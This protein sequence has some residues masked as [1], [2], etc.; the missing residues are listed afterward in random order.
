MGAGMTGRD[1]LMSAHALRSLGRVIEAIG[2]PE[3]AGEL[4]GTLLSLA[5]FDNL[6]AVAFSPEGAPRPL[7]TFVRSSVA[8]ELYTRHY[9]SGAYRLDPYYLA[10][11]E[12][13]RGFYRL[14]DVVPDLFFQGEYFRGYYERTGLID[15]IGLVAPL[16]DRLWLHFSL[17]RG[18]RSR[19]FSRAEL[20][21]LLAMEPIV[22]SLVLRHWRDA[23]VVP[24][25]PELAEV[26]PG[27]VGRQD[28]A[29]E[30]L[31]G[32]ILSAITAASGGTP[33]TKR[34][35]E[36]TAYVLRGHSSASIGLILGISFNT[37]KVH[38]RRA[39]AKLGVA[40]QAELFAKL[41][42]VLARS[43]AGSRSQYLGRSGHLQLERLS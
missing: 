2:E 39:Y 20:R 28:F 19:R 11:R 14:S 42:P 23:I 32:R 43:A 21:L 4:N 33:L 31:G 29:A 8:Q 26:G 36:I 40:S 37:I 15:E 6:V 18:E 34:E 10:C 25:P 35:A 13:R 16:H 22:T 27:D 1:V 12:G 5:D 24:V 30:E 17:S 41:L 9:F 3:F 38:R 7:C